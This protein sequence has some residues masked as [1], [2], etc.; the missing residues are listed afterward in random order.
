MQKLMYHPNVGDIRGIGL[1]RGIEIVKDKKTMCPFPRK[2][3]YVERVWDAL[4]E[5][6]VIAYKS[7]G[8]ARG[9]GDAVI[10]A[11]PFII[12]EDQI[13]FI[14][15]AFYESLN[16]ICGT[17]SILYPFYPYPANSREK[18]LL[19][20]G[21]VLSG[22][23]ATILAINGGRRA[24]ASI[25]KLMYG[26]SLENEPHLITKQS[27]IQSIHHVEGVDISPRN[28]MPVAPEGKDQEEFLGFTDEQ[29]VKEAERCLRC[30]LICY[31]RSPVH[32]E[33]KEIVAA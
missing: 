29:A 21:D 19:S 5:K 12:N 8:F 28:I 7:S 27:I 14:V 2:K 11:P 6:G 31:K 4:F 10:F 24:A 15:H 13:N 9:D 22:Y 33:E 16:K 23:S 26:I 17:S 25:H 3:K 1:F 20:R 18:G 30:G 32:G